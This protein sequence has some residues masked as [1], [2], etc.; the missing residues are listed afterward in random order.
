MLSNINYTN[1]KAVVLDVDNTLVYS[2]D[3]TTS[4]TKYNLSTLDSYNISFRSYDNYEDTTMTVYLRPYVKQFIS[5]L[6]MKYKVGIWSMG[7]PNY[8][9]EISKILDIGTD[10]INLTSKHKVSFIYDWTHCIREKQR[11]YKPLK[12]CP[13]KNTSSFIIEDKVSSC[14]YNDPQFIIQPFYGNPKDTSLFDFI[15]TISDIPISLPI[16]TSI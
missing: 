1:Y 4:D 7:Q 14:D 12:E 5:T 11:I 16:P 15:Q 6:C 2:T 10:V 8:I 13:F 9:S 3:T